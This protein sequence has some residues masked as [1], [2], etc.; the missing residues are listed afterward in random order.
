[1][2]NGLDIASERNAAIA[3]PD[4]SSYSPEEARSEAVST[5]NVTGSMSGRCRSR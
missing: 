5:P 4:K 3:G 2:V 1:M